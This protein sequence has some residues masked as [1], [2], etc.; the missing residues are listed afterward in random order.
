MNYIHNIFPIP[1]YLN[2]VKDPVALDQEITNKLTNI[3]W[4]AGAGLDDPHRITTA[5]Y[6]DDIIMDASLS[7]FQAELDIHLRAYANSLLFPL[8]EYSRASWLAEYDLNEY[9]T[10]HDHGTADISGVYYYKTCSKGGEFFFER[11]GTAHT[12]H[13]YADIGDRYTIRPQPGLLIMFPGWMRHGVTRNLS[14]EC[15]RI[16]SFNL[17]FDRTSAIR[18]EIADAKSRYSTPS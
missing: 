5:S 13:A 16:L 17:W 15:R 8:T 7:V 14:G 4:I 12:A 11:P 3:R 18:K 2:Q 1:V 10:V 9:S 6:Y